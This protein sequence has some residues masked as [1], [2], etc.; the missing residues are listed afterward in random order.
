MLRDKSLH[1]VLQAVFLLLRLL[2]GA[3]LHRIERLGQHGA[4]LPHG[5][6]GQK[7]ARGLLS[8]G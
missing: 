4:H 2:R 5:A 8:G 6:A 1:A 7:P 3:L